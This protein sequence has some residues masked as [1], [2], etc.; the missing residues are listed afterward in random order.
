[1]LNFM[2]SLVELNQG[3]QEEERLLQEEKPLEQCI[4]DENQEQHDLNQQ[5]VNQKKCEEE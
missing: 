1:M 3:E 5:G 4:Q 2:K